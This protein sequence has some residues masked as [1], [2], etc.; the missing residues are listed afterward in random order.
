MDSKK[1][2]IISVVIFILSLLVFISTVF[3]VFVKPGGDGNGDKKQN[4]KKIETQNVEIG[5]VSTQVGD[6]G[7]FYKGFVYL[8]VKGKKTPAK[9][10]EKMPQIKDSIISAIS[11]SDTSAITSE[12]GMNNLKE[13]IKKNVNEIIGTEDVVNVLF[14]QSILQ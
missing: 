7:R 10:E 3:L 12:E 8:E 11:Y 6:S 1:F 14:T 4:N 2:A 9:I 13:E 5:D